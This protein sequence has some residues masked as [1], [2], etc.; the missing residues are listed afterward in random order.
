MTTSIQALAFDAYGT[1]FDV[2]SV[3]STC[4]QV[5][6]DKGPALSQLWRAKQLEYTWLRSLMRLSL[7]RTKACTGAPRRSTPNAG[8]ACEKTPPSNAATAISSAAVTDPC[9]PLP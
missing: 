6:P 5:F 9:P 1:L 8:N 4:N 2:H 7:N 3:I